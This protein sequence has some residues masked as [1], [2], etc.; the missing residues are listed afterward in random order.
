MYN[1]IY[2][3]SDKTTKKYINHDILC[4]DGENLTTEEYKKHISNFE[5]S[6]KLYTSEG[7]I[8][9]CECYSFHN[10]NNMCYVYIGKAKYID[11]LNKELNREYNRTNRSSQKTIKK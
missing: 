3:V 6:K 9:G 10:R 2:K 4:G 5:N 8:K 11:E 7:N 1:I